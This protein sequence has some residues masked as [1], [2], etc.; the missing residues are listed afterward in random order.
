MSSIGSIH[1]QAAK[2]LSQKQDAGHYFLAKLIKKR[3]SV[4]GIIGVIIRCEIKAPFYGFC[5]KRGRKTY[6][7][8]EF[9]SQR[10]EYILF[11]SIKAL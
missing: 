6:K 1:G 11:F 5:C 9:L 3:T 7:N 4:K 2:Y 10:A 8:Y